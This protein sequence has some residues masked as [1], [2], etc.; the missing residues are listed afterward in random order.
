MHKRSRNHG[1]L[2]WILRTWVEVQWP[3]WYPPTHVCMPCGCLASHG[4]TPAPCMPYNCQ[5]ASF[6]QAGFYSCSC[7]PLY[8]HG[9]PSTQ[10]SCD[11][12]RLNLSGGNHTGPRNAVH[13]CQGI[14]LSCNSSENQCWG[15]KA[16]AEQLRQIWADTKPSAISTHQDKLSETASLTVIT[17]LWTLYIEPHAQSLYIFITEEEWTAASCTAHKRNRKT[18][19]SKKNRMWDTEKSFWEKSEAVGLERKLREIYVCKAGS[20]FQAETYFVSV[21][22]HVHN[23][24]VLISTFA[25]LPVLSDWPHIAGGANPN[26]HIPAKL[27]RSGWISTLGCHSPE[28]F[29]YCV[30]LHTSL[31]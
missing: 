2:R 30:P 8:P 13:L 3:S 14:V 6:C 16:S 27:P 11:S 19:L 17:T 23:K 5:A 18:T 25:T 31:P 24:P 15:R 9:L 26:Q 22:M 28:W 4:R 29:S 1:W 21:R 20:V 10:T 7:S 12:A